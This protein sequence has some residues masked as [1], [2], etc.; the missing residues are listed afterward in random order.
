MMKYFALAILLTSLIL[1]GCDAVEEKAQIK[2]TPPPPIVEEKTP[3]VEP[4]RDFLVEM[5]LTEPQGDWPEA[6]PVL[7]WLDSLEEGWNEVK[8]EGRPLLVLV[9]CPGS[10]RSGQFANDLL[11]PTPEMAVLL[12]QFITVHI[13]DGQEIDLNRMPFRRYQD[14]DQTWWCWI[15]SPQGQVYSVLGR[16]SPES[17]EVTWSDAVQWMSAVLDHHWDPRRED[18]NADGEVVPI[19]TPMRSIADNPEFQKWK[20]SVNYLGDLKNDGQC[21]C[22]HQ[23][24]DVLWTEKK[25]GK[26]VSYEKRLL[27]LASRGK[28]GCECRG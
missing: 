21:I 2:P 5:F 25:T 18:W 12:R 23:M 19:S 22:C 1:G 11:N 28:S 17:P 7:T 10:S 14:P 20:S 3:A 26:K 27:D 6:A 24:Q 16:I 15:L 9:H 13:T 8:N 4:Q